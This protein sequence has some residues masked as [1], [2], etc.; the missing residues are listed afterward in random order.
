MHRWLCD[1]IELA[2]RFAANAGVKGSI[3]LTR[4]NA[5]CEWFYFKIA[6]C[7]KLPASPIIGRFGYTSE[8]VT[9]ASK[10]ALRL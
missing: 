9:K 6:L 10:I 1:V 8:Q 2:S 5:F 3:Y 7:K 4:K